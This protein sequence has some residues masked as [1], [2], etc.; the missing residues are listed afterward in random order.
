M[1]SAYCTACAS[2]AYRLRSLV[3]EQKGTGPRLDP[4]KIP[5][6]IARVE[7]VYATIRAIDASTLSVTPETLFEPGS[8]DSQQLKF[9][10]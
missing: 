5:C 2:P 3:N 10:K 7:E 9:F 4:W 1:S 8:V 6:L